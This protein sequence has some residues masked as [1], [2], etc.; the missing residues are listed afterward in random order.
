[1]HAPR[2]GWAG[3]L[4]HATRATPW[5]LARTAIPAVVLHIYGMAMGVSASTLLGPRKSCLVCR[6][7]YIYDKS[8]TAWKT[9]VLYTCCGE[10]SDCRSHRRFVPWLV[11]L[12]PHRPTYLHRPNLI[13]YVYRPTS[14]ALL[15]GVGGEGRKKRTGRTAARSLCGHCRENLIMGWGRRGAVARVVDFASMSLRKQSLSETESVN[16]L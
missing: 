1:M 14:S 4:C 9:S 3:C 16:A 11:C 5:A 13:T 8:R 6:C 15:L 7:G 2:R 10:Q 12:S